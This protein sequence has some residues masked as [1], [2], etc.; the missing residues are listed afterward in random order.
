MAPSRRGPRSP[1]PTGCPGSGADH[2]SKPLKDG[3]PSMW[4]IRND[5]GGSRPASSF[6][7]GP[8]IGMF[9]STGSPTAVTA[10]NPMCTT[11]WHP[12]SPPSR[13]AGYSALDLREV[14]NG[15]G[16]GPRSC[17]G[18]FPGSGAGLPGEVEAPRSQPDELAGKGHLSHPSWLAR[19]VSLFG[20]GTTSIKS[21]MM[22]GT[23]GTQ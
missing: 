11:G 3:S 1:A 19:A 22:H 5:C 4:I 15:T 8:Q 10:A 16:T 7:T 20:S 23:S 13:G 6:D 17:S 2:P 12:I 9:Q 18:L 14:Q 21:M